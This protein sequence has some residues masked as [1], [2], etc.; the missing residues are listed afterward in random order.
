VAPSIVVL[1]TDRILKGVK[2][3]DKRVDLSEHRCCGDSMRWGVC[4]CEWGNYFPSYAMKEGACT[5]EHL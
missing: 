4:S 1:V 5:D 2:R 3:S